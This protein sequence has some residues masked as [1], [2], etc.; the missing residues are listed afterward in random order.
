MSMTQDMGM[1]ISSPMMQRTVDY[2]GPSFMNRRAQHNRAK[3]SQL[4]GR[5]KKLVER[6][7]MY[8][9]DHANARP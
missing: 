3:S 7:S 2:S 8:G 1:N 6:L 9:I 4:K 5:S